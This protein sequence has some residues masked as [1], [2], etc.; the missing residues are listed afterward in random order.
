MKKITKNILSTAFVFA[1]LSSFLKASNNSNEQLNFSD[2]NLDWSVNRTVRLLKRETSRHVLYWR[3]AD[4]CKGNASSASHLL[5]GRTSWGKEHLNA[6]L[7]LE[8]EP[9]KVPIT[10][11]ESLLSNILHTFTYRLV[12]LRMYFCCMDSFHYSSDSR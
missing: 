10:H 5:Y 1:A 4:A 8:S 11:Y 6:S 3:I 12:N 7:I 9:R 2:H